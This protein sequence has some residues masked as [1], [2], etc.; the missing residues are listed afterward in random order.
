M[1]AQILSAEETGDGIL[2]TYGYAN[3]EDYLA[4]FDVHV[5][6]DVNLEEQLS[7]EDL[8]VLASRLSKQVE[9]NEE[10]R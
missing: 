2:L 1:F 8:E 6:D 7:D 9:E 5:T 4:D 3:P 10:L